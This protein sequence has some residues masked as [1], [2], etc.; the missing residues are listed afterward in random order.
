MQE[1]NSE[2]KYCPICLKEHEV[3]TVRTS[4]SINYKD[5]LIIAKSIMDY[6]EVKD[7]LIETEAQMVSNATLIIEAYEDKLSRT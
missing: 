1:I 7:E 3:K 4:E 5:E 2:I 6:C